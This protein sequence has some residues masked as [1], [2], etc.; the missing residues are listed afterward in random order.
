MINNTEEFIAVLKRYQCVGVNIYVEKDMPITVN[1]EYQVGKK[2]VTANLIDL[3]NAED[4]MVVLTRIEELTNKGEGSLRVFCRFVPENK[5]YLICCEMRREKHLGKTAAFCLFGVIMDVDEFNKNME[6][7]PTQQELSS[8]KNN[9]NSF[10]SSGASGYTGIVDI[11]G[12]DLLSRIQLPLSKNYGLSSAIL[13]ESGKFICSSDPNQVEFDVRNH[14]HSRQNYI[15]INNEVF[16]VWVIVSDDISLIER[17]TPAHDVLVESLTIISNSYVLL[18]NEMSNNENANKL[19][20]EIVEQQMLLSGIYN[21]VLNERNT[22]STVKA[23]VDLTGEFLKL[24]RVIVYENV[25]Y[26]EKHSRVYEWD[27]ERIKKSINMGAEFKKSPIEFRYS[28][29]P[30][31]IEELGSYETY[32]SNNPEHNVLGLNF[33]S[34]VAS[35]LSGDGSNVGIIIYLVDNPVRILSH[36]E[37]RLLRSVSQ[38]IAA[39]IMRCKDNEQLDI[40]SKRLHDLAYH[41]HLLGVKNR[42]SLT[43]DIQKAVKS[44]KTGAVFAFKIPNIEHINSFEGHGYT[45]RLL[46]GILESFYHNEI[47]P[48]EPYR[49]SDNVFMILLRDVNLDETRK[50]CELT[51]ARFNEPWV[52]EEKE[53]YLRIVAGVSL[54][55]NAG[56]TADEIYRTVG[57]AM[58]RAQGYDINSYAFYSG[59]FAPERNDD[60]HCAQILRNAVNNNMEG[61]AIEYSPIYEMDNGEQ[62]V[63][64][65]EVAP[66]ISHLMESEVYSPRITMMIAE[67]M[68]ISSN[69]DA[70]LINKACD[71]CVKERI[72]SPGVSVSV[73][74]SA[75]SLISG[76]IVSIAKNALNNSGL[77]ADGLLLQFS[78][79]IVATNYEQFMK[80]LRKLSEFD[81]LAVLDDFGSYYVTS[82]LIRHSGI[83]ALKADVV[84]FTGGFDDEFGEKYIAGLM[85]L[86]EKNGVKIG[87][88]SIENESQ[89]EIGFVQNADWYQG[90]YYSKE[91]L[92]AD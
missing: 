34:Y 14:R 59:E 63:I 87:V 85:K 23:I 92:K 71:F 55:P 15:K 40:T 32:Y 47:V 56:D 6:S 16:A 82:E 48:A 52:F 8:L 37:K 89:L 2:A 18:Y 57:I 22:N 51:T 21:K 35:N 12:K 81:V 44:G 26:E 67:K 19:L 69:I 58:E 65:Y 49:F 27:S 11:V 41:D 68:G 46:K 3:I 75:H 61:I 60:Y 25:S 7:D 28:E 73:G 91:F 9:M 43:N 83:C 72:D 42:T 30:E 77:S 70:W 78:E 90:G 38:I 20:S 80:V 88:R 17:Y 31:L 24:D 29:Y 36:A 76:E 13:T 50:F 64:S 45:D 62:R 1:K 53:H 79:R 74:V 33:S 84:L 66:M 4:L 5:R 10:S 54:F 86:A 39:V